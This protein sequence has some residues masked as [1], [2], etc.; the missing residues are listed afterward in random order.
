MP[1]IALGIE[2]NGSCYHGWQRQD[3]NA[4]TIQA[5]LEDALS[6]VANHPVEVY[7]AGRT[8]AGVHGLGQVVHFDTSSMRKLDAWVLGS[9]SKLPH[10]ICVRWAKE[11]PDDFHARFSAIARQYYYFIDNRRIPAAIFHNKVTCHRNKL[12]EIKMAEAAQY[13]LGEQDFSSYRSAACQSKTPIRNVMHLKIVRQQ[14]LIMIDIKAN[15]FLHHMVRNIVGVL[16][17]IGERKQPPIWAKEVLLARDRKVAAVTAPANGLYLY[18]VEYL[19][20]YALDV[21]SSKLFFIG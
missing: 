21:N 9:N 15:A 14:D 1:R 6:F 11:M 8:D 13:L 20:K 5:K 16:M 2:Y 12:D 4:K 18:A 3:D 19:E 17:T 10:D 7:C